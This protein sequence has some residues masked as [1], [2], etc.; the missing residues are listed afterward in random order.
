M[1]DNA[2]RVA[3]TWLMVILA[4]LMIIWALAGGARAGESQTGTAS[5]YGPGFHGHRTA[6]GTLYN[7]WGMT[8]A[9]PPDNALAP[10]MMRLR[11]GDV[12]EVIDLKTSKHVTVTI[13]DR[14]PFVKGR[15]LDLSR[16]A[17]LA[18]WGGRHVP[19]RGVG[20][21]RITP[22]GRGSGWGS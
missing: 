8:A 18:L 13:T 10:G 4:V 14:G 6:C 7:E 20:M 12:I 17:A 11:C 15:M 19:G 21:V 16:G 9:Y 5:W 3:L 22:I 1:A 2:G